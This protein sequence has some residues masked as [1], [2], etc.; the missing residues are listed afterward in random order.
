MNF[1]CMQSVY[2][3]FLRGNHKRTVLRVKFRWSLKSTATSCVTATSDQSTS[4]C[5]NYLQAVFHPVTNCNVCNISRF[6]KSDLLQCR[7]KI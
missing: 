7:L 4:L 1:G 2:S 6:K 3:F 5:F